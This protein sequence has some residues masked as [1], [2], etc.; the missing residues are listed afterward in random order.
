MNDGNMVEDV[1]A[2]TK[3][4]MIYRMISEHWDKWIRKNHIPSSVKWVVGISGGKDSTVVAASSAKKFGKEN[5]IGVTLPCDGQRD[6]DDSLKVI[7]HLGIRHVNID[8]GDAVRS[9]LDGVEN[10]AIDVSY[11]TKTNLPARVRMSTLYAV[12]QSVGGIVL[13]TC[14][15]TED[16]LGYCSMFGDNCGSYAPIRGLT[17][18]EVIELGDWLGV[19]RELTHKTPV[20]GLQPLSDEEKLGM[21][22]AD[23]DAFIRRG[24]GS[25]E[26][27]QKVREMYLRNKFKCEIVNVPGCEMRFPNF[28]SNNLTEFDEML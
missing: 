12:A 3:S 4:E 1:L 18:T 13:N 19:P 23:V 6:F 25:E 8:I 21:K 27:K 16:I 14:N 9:I 20:D 24:E 22:Y 17:V 26:L 2:E 10:N 5:V 15:L 7:S 11:D 28:V